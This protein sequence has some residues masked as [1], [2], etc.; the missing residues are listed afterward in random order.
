MVKY[1]LNSGDEHGSEMFS[2][3]IWGKSGLGTL[4]DTLLSKDIY[5]SDLKLLLIQY[6]VEGEF[7]RY[8]P[9]EPKVNNYS[10]KNKDIS[11]AIGVPKSLFHDRNEFERREFIVDTTLNAIEM[12]KVKLEK[13]KLDIDFLALV[14]DVTQLCEEYLKKKGNYY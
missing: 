9:A 6:Y 7:S 14:H 8:L 4:I 2:P 12:V 5:G 11:V 1:Y 3:Y 13:K 10:T